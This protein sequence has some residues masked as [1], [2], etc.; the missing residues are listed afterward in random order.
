M[1]KTNV[2]RR[3]KQRKKKETMIFLASAIIAVRCDMRL[4]TTGIMRL[5]KTRGPRLARKKKTKKTKKT[6]K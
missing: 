4:Q 2:P 6:K 3:I 1:N 5:I